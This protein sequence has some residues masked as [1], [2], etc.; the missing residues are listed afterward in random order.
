MYYIITESR[1]ISSQGLL[2][3]DFKWLELKN[4]KDVQLKWDFIDKLSRK[5]TGQIQFIPSDKSK[6]P[7]LFLNIENPLDVY[8]EIQETLE[9]NN[10]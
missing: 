7:V 9:K 10:A 3:C 1:V 6:S 2:S 4:I 8:I 5:K